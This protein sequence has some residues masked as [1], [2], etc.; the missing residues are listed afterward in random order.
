MQP[1]HTQRRQRRSLSTPC[2]LAA[3]VCIDES[4]LENPRGISDTLKCPICIGILHDPVFC[5]GQ[6]CQHV[7]CRSC[8]EEA[9]LISDR[10]PVCRKTIGKEDLYPNQMV[11]S[12]LDEVMVRC[13][14]KCGWSG[15]SDAYSGHISACPKLLLEKE[16]TDM[17]KLREQYSEL[18]SKLAHWVSQNCALNQQIHHLRVR[19]DLA[20]VRNSELLQRAKDAGASDVELAKALDADD[21]RRVLVEMLISRSSQNR[22][23]KWY[24]VVTVVQC[25]L[26]WVSLARASQKARKSLSGSMTPPAASVATA[27]PRRHRRRLAICMHVHH[28]FAS[29]LD[30]GGS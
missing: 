7:F 27:S 18:Q 26:T 12:L 2:P 10:C 15:R 14:H 30:F 28:P 9:M 6:P 25:A 16:R 13:E 20:E 19:A 3:R 8:I 5:G 22:L 1:K 24:T 4:Q 17:T 23:K 11:L 21:L 29:R